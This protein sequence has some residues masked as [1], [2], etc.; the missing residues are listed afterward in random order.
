MRY[1]PGDIIL[2]GKYRVEGWLGR[3]S[4][5]EVYRAWDLEHRAMRALRVVTRDMP[6]VDDLAV[7]D[8][9][10]RF[11]LAAQLGA[12]LDHPHVLKV[13]GVEEGEGELALVMEFA[14]GGSLQDRLDAEGRLSIDQTARLAVEACQ[15]L[16]AIH[17]QLQAVHRDLKPSNILFGEGGE[18]RIADLGR[19]QVA[20]RVQ[21]QHPGDPAYASPEQERSTAPLLPT[22]DLFSLGCVLFECLTGKTYKAANVRGSRVREHRRVTPVW[23]DAILARALAEVPGRTPED[24]ALPG[25]RYRTAE[26]MRADL[27]RGWRA[28]VVRREEQAR[29]RKEAEGRRGRRA[30]GW[31]IVAVGLLVAIA[32]A[33]AVARPLWADWVATTLPT[34][35]P[36]PT[37]DAVALAEAPTDT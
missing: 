25:R 37:G 34:P 6:G 23:L 11:A 22:S 9:R 33:V 16:S 12:V 13:Y 27:E 10:E 15:G 31:T 21:G 19:A 35:S 29:R 18:A 26:Q 1:R 36:P 8:C 20:G 28:L 3:G 14:P 5:G 17:E 7:R 30:L 24:D 2:N 4:L 32:L